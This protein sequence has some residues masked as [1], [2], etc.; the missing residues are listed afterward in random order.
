MF[1]L[2]CIPCLQAASFY[3]TRMGFEPFAYKGLETGSRSV[4]AHAVKQN[5]IIFV[6]Q[7]QLMP[8]TPEG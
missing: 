7:S 3:C 1:E 4:V 6:L 5:D 2:N 8:N